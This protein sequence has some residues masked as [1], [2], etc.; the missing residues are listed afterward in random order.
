MVGL[1]FSSAVEANWFYETAVAALKR[2][3]GQNSKK[4]SPVKPE[5]VHENSNEVVLR[6]NNQPATGN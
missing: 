2:H 6:N 1:N 4:S 5:T 3:P